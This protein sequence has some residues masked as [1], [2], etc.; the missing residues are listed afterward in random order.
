MVDI[1]YPPSL[2]NKELIEH[3]LETTEIDFQT[4][5]TKVYTKVF[6]GD[7]FDHEKGYLQIPLGLVSWLLKSLK[8][9]KLLDVNL[10]S[11]K[12]T[13]EDTFNIFNV[14][15]DDYTSLYNF[16]EE[17]DI[18][19]YDHQVL[20]IKSL[21]KQNLGI[22]SHPT[23][24]GKGEII[25]GLS[26]ILQDYGQV[27]VVL[28]NNSS[29]VSTAKRFDT[30]KI[31]YYDYHKIRGMSPYYRI[32][33]STPK[34]VLNDIEKGGSELI[35]SI[36][37]LIVNEVHHGQAFTWRDLAVK[38]PN[39]VRSY[40]LSATP[41]V[42]DVECIRDM[43][44]R[45]AMIR[46]AHGDIIATVKSKNIKDL[47]SVPTVINVEYEP[48][49]FNKNHLH[50]FNWYK[51]KHYINRPHRMEAVAN[52]VNVINDLTGFTTITF[53]SQIKK[54]GDALFNLY[55]EKTAC[56]YGGGVIKT[57]SGQVFDKKTIFDAVDNGD[58]KHLIV[59][60]HAREDINLPTLNI[61]VMMELTEPG[62]VKQCVGRIVRKGT[63]SFF[64]NL[65]D[66]VPKLLNIQANK[67]SKII[68]D[69]YQSKVLRCWGDEEFGEIIK[70]L[71]DDYLFVKKA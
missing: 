17:K 66:K 28:P 21:L 35:N 70:R 42:D 39:I 11:I 2:E 24:S 68:Q 22:L 26:K 45:E 3:I 36:K 12:D 60:S 15:F 16:E 7:I 56:W 65:S 13:H 41:K 8:K 30:Y 64:V 52:L 71:W 32:I 34:V 29:L 6:V 31:P 51:I 50:E 49:K 9:M 54:Q 44:L 57:K 59:T 43:T 38:L 67:R 40:G 4:D 47:I 62:A 53:V 23:G 19:L 55:P 5:G 25:I 18:T 37:Y 33:L 61:G 14:N 27:L 10:I 1:Y 58:V 46:G 63:P 48:V 69:E 20:G